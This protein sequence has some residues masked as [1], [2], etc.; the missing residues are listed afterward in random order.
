M[1]SINYDLIRNPV[2]TEKSTFLGE[3]QKYVFEVSKFAHKLSVKKAVEA[4]FNVKV[5]S[6]NI[7]NKKGK[8]KRFKG[9]K[10]CRADSK[11]AIVTLMGDYSIDMSGGVK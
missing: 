6:V 11:K 9:V 3:Q 5:E 4:I 10:G 8:V 1:T 7:L 2:I